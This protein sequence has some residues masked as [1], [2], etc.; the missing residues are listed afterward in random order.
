MVKDFKKFERAKSYDNIFVLS[1]RSGV[2]DVNEMFQ[3]VLKIKG[4][5]NNKYY[6]F[7]LS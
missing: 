7:S 5:K 3:G 6:H 2:I 4:S 1:L